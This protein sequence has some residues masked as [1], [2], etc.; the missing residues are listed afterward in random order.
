MKHNL[1]ILGIILTM[2]GAALFILSYVPIKH[3]S[4][5]ANESFEI[6]SFE[7]YYYSGIFLPN[8]PLHI[9]FEVQLGSLDFIVFNET[10]LIKW[11]ASQPYEHYSEPSRPNASYSDIIWVPPANTRIYF[12]WDNSYSSL[13]KIVF[14][15]VYVEYIEPLL[16]PLMSVSGIFLL[17]AG[18]STIGYGSRPPTPNSSQKTIILGYIFAALGGLVGLLFGIELTISKNDESK[19]HGKVIATI[20]ATATI[21]YVLLL[22]V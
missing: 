18:L 9:I 5:L 2:I 15:L 6:P 1:I 20:G 14:T 21:V 17:F 4:T 3:S 22:F 12:V 16:P 13:S 10:N 11:N 19:H 7:W 8:T